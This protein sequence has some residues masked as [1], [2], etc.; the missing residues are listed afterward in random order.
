[1]SDLVGNPEDRFSRVAAQ[2]VLWGVNVFCSRTQHDDA[3]GDLA[4][5]LSIRSLMLYYL[6]MPQCSKV[7]NSLPLLPVRDVNFLG[8]DLMS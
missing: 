1:M 4:Q 7:N 5:D 6:I 3:C 8:F 2:T